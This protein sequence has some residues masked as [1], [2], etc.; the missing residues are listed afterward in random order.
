MAPHPFPA[1]A[2]N[3]AHAQTGTRKSRDTKPVVG[4]RSQGKF[5]D[6]VLAQASGPPVHWAHYII[7]QNLRIVHRGVVV[8]DIGVH[9]FT[10]SRTPACDDEAIQEAYNMI[11][12]NVAGDQSKA[13]CK[14]GSHDG[15]GAEGI[16]GEGGDGCW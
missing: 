14:L 5:E 12:R 9:L 2:C 10:K 4:K 1:C 6:I 11:R 8:G 3:P 13:D 16:V 7:Q 15:L